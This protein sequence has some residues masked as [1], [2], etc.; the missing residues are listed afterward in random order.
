MLPPDTLGLLQGPGGATEAQARLRQQD[1]AAVVA[2]A[3]EEEEATRRSKARLYGEAKNLEDDF[4][5]IRPLI[6]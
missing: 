3:A 4:E 1:R 2:A 6:E 5:Q